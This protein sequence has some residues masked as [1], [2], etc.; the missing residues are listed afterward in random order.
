MGFLAKI[1]KAGVVAYTASALV[2][3][4]KSDAWWIRIWDFPR[5]QLLVLGLALGFIYLWSTKDTPNRRVLFASLLVIGAGLDL[6][7]TLPYSRVW[8]VESLPPKSHAPERQFSLFIANVLQENTQAEK[9][10]RLI[11]KKSPD[12]ILLVEVNERWLTALAALDNDYRFHLKK[13]QENEYGIAFYSRL[14]LEAAEIRYLIEP[15]IP[16]VWARVVLRS[17]DRIEVFGLHPRPPRE[18]AGPT[19]ERDAELVQVAS[20]A[21][22]SSHP[23]VVM[24][25]LNDVAWS[26]TTRL[27]RRISGLLDPRVGRGSYPTFPAQFPFLRFPLDYV[28]HSQSLRLVAIERLGEIGSDHFPMYAAFSFEPSGRISQSG[29]STD[30][31]DK[32]EVRDTIGKARE[33]NADP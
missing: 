2:P 8:R 25:D 30:K 16:S 26:H 19:T 9:L 31:G 11:A 24:G 33:R 23:V 18:K 7:R 14:P 5:L 10:L 29:P 4:S 12:L 27:F 1:G 15:T 17:G 20:V 3:L 22:R 13:P 32:E 6:Y 28:F 21:R